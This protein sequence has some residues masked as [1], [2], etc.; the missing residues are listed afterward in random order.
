MKKLDLAM[1]EEK[2]HQQDRLN[3]KSS[4]L[5]KRLAQYGYENL[6]EYFY[7]KREFLFSQWNPEVYHV[8]VKTLTAELEQAIQNNQFGIYL[9]TT[10]GPYV[11][12]GSDVID[13]ALCEELDVTVAEVFYH[14]GTI[15][16]GPED[17]G[18]AIVAPRAIGLEHSYIITK[19]FELLNLK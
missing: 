16:G 9:S 18:I 6:Q 7:E 5:A 1:L 17:L 13:Y 3:G 12:H 14:G 4:D 2:Q 11:F 15:V 8:A 10:D 19:F